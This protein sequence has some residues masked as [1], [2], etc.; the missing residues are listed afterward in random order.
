MILATL[1][2]SER[3][4]L[5]NPRFKKAFEWLKS[6][7]L[8]LLE[9]EKLVLEPGVLLVNVSDSP[10]KDKGNAKLEC[11][12][13]YVD[14]QVPIT[15]AENYGW[16]DRNQCTKVLKPFDA[17]KDIIFYGDAPTTY[18]TL[19]PGQFCIFFPE[20]A[21][22]PCVGTNGGVLKKIIIKVAVI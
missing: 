6:E 1:K 7:D 10:L 12:H 19:Q 4:E 18:F 15:G 21:H 13:H 22:A 14:I 2:E 9:N 3:Y 20:D 5:L 17:A 11:H 8:M 16:K